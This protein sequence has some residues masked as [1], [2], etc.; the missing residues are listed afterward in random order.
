MIQRSVHAQAALVSLEQARE[1]FAEGQAAL[2]AGDSELESG[3][4]EAMQEA[5]ETAA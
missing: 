3:A 5:L 1:F 2:L 4:Y